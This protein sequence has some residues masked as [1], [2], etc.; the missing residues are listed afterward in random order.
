[1]DPLLNL[2]TRRLVISAALRA[3]ARRRLGSGSVSLESGSDDLLAFA[4]E[5]GEEASTIEREYRLRFDPAYPG[6]TAGPQSAG[7]SCRLVL[8]CGAFDP[9]GSPI[10]VVFTALI[11]GRHPQVSVA[12][13]E[14]AIPEDWRP[15]IDPC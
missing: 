14:A 13:A 7:G 4:R 12:P 3:R 2:E 1:M 5:L 9:D 11:P 10:G 15:L 8:A 6:V